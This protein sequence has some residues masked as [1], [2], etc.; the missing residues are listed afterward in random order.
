MPFRN[1][2]T[3]LIP[4]AMHVFRVDLFV[5]CVRCLRRMPGWLWWLDNPY[6]IRLYR[7]GCT[8]WRTFL[9][10]V[11]SCRFS[12]LL[13]VSHFIVQYIS[14]RLGQVFTFTSIPLHHRFREALVESGKEHRKDL[15]S[16]KNKFYLHYLLASISNC[17]ILKWDH[18]A[19]NG[20]WQSCQGFI[21]QMKY[22]N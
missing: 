19:V 11:G 15:S 5:L 10:G 2:R 14:V 1:T 20:P 16:N 21:E 6:E 13:P 4:H 3:K 18:G 9:T 17:I 7:W 12:F 22:L 8:R